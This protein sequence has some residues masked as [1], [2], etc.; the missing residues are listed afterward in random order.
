M[1]RREMEEDDEGDEVF[2]GAMFIAVRL[3]CDMT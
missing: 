2:E 1:L 3:A